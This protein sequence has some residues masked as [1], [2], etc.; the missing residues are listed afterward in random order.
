MVTWQ[1]C[2]DG[3]FEAQTKEVLRRTEERLMIS[4]DSLCRARV[5]LRNS[6]ERLVIRRHEQQQASGDDGNGR[7][8]SM[9]LLSQ[10][11]HA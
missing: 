1:R 7:L 3:E 4:Y 9:P 2:N 6:D 10:L 11:D 5:T 8:Q